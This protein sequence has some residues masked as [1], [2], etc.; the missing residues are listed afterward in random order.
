MS[1]ACPQCWQEHHRCGGLVHE[2]PREHILAIGIRLVPVHR[3]QLY[4]AYDG[5]RPGTRAQAASKQPIVATDG[6]GL[7]LVS[8]QLLSAGSCPSP[9]NRVK[10]TQRCRL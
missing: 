3:R 2:L 5:S 4:Q 1:V 10:I 7:D 6:N 8:I 9:A